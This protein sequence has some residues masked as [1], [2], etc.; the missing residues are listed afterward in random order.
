MIASESFIVSRTISPFSSSTISTSSGFAIRHTSSSRSF[1]RTGA[2]SCRRGDA[3]VES[4][5]GVSTSAACGGGWNWHSV[6]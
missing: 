5:A 4:A 2:Y 3:G 6:W 1:E